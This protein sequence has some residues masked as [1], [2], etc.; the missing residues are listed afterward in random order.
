[1]LLGTACAMFFVGPMLVSEAGDAEPGVRSRW[2]F[3]SL[4]AIAVAGVSWLHGDSSAVESSL[5][6][7]DH[8]TWFTRGLSLTAGLILVL[9]MWNQIDDAHSAEAYACLLTILA[10]T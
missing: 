9:T 2:G 5:F 1:M 8:L 6:R 7:I 10:G 4:I 3:I